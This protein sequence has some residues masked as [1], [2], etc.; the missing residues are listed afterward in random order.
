LFGQNQIKF[1]FRYE[2]DTSEEDE[3]VNN[4]SRFR[5]SR[6]II[7]IDSHFSFLVVP[8]VSL[9]CMNPKEHILII[10]VVDK[11][12]NSDLYETPVIKAIQIL[13]YDSLWTTKKKDDRGN[14]FVIRPVEEG[15]K[16]ESRLEYGDLSTYPIGNVLEYPN[17][18]TFLDAEH[19]FLK[20]KFKLKKTIESEEIDI[21]VYWEMPRLNKQGFYSLFKVRLL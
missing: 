5:V 20:N 2:I 18:K 16:P 14:L 4:A 8:Q 21:V 3:P 15:E 7:N 19:L 10:Q 11:L 1:L 12:A 6:A 9:S 17:L 13:N